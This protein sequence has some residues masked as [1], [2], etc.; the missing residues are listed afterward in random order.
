MK[1]IKKTD[2]GVVGH[3]IHLTIGELCILKSYTEAA[4]R[5]LTYNRSKSKLGE[6]RLDSDSVGQI[7]LVLKWLLKI[8]AEAESF[9]D[10][11]KSLGMIPEEKTVAVVT[12]KEDKNLTDYN[13]IYEM[14]P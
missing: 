8:T 13:R 6:L 3:E 10:A 5:V 1:T 2:I 14:A 12:S 7:E 9:D 11:I 4:I